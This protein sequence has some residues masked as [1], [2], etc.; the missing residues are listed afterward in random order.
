MFEQLLDRIVATAPDVEPSRMRGADAERLVEKI[1]K[2]ERVLAAVRTVAA[3]RV[4][5]SNVWQSR[6]FRRAE[7][8][9]A[10]VS[11][12]SL[13]EAKVTLQTARRLEDLPLVSRAFLGGDL[14]EVQAR[15]VSDAAYADPR[16]ERAL[17]TTAK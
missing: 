12:I 16:H 8:W 11:G 4:E 13:G 1:A 7:D 3:R 14:S 2:A 6:G 17:V 9:M 5:E 15:D 10:K